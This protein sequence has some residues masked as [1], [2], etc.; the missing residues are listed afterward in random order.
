MGARNAPKRAEACQDVEASWQAFCF[1]HYDGLAKTERNA[2]I[3][4][5]FQKELIQL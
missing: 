2:Y 3:C 4:S 1:F 5:V